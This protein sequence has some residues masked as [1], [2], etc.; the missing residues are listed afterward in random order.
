MVYAAT[1]YFVYVAVVGLLS[2][3]LSGRSRWRAV[4]AAG[5]GLALTALTASTT[6]FWLRDVL[7]PP[8]LLLAAYWASGLLWVGPMPRAERLL[9]EV[10]RRLRVPEIAL[11]LPR[12]VSAFFELAYAGVY[13]LIPIALALH[14]HYADTPDPE[15]FWAVILVT[16]F[17]CFGMLP[18]IQ[19]RPPRV[20]E[21]LLPVGSRL[22]SFNLTL[23]GHTSVGVNT[24]PSGHA[25]EAVAVALLLSGAPWPI[26]VCMSLSALVI[27]AG[28]VLGRY[29]YTLD[30]LTGWLVALGVWTW[31]TQAI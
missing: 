9:A 14:V 25:A 18:W 23:L 20:L 24:V 30:V 21:L 28:A 11:W 2:P 6:T 17:V 7:L 8:V 5:G 29:H 27:S 26:I 12:P 15:R 16:D 13:P 1:L 31:R 19:T 10:D 22:R 3:G 4:R